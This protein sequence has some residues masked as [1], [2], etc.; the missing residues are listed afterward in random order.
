MRCGASAGAMFIVYLQI[1]IVLCSCPNTTLKGPNSCPPPS[2]SWLQ[3]A[4]TTRN[5]IPRPDT[6][7]LLLTPNS[8]R[9]ASA[10][11]VRLLSLSTL[12]HL[13]PVILQRYR[14]L[15][16]SQHITTHPAHHAWPCRRCAEWQRQACTGDASPCSGP[17][18]TWGSG[19][20]EWRLQPAAC[21]RV[22]TPA[23]W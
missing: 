11:L 23:R 2:R 19:S 17:R 8:A 20:P 5:A 12:I 13:L 7:Y 1:A 14:C 15:L 16:E 18:C 6:R 4:A 10:R 22:R 21:S 3:G 9:S